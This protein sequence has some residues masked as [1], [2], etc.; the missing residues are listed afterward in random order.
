M[1][2]IYEL[3]CHTKEVS[4]CSKVGVEQLVKAHK[5]AGFS[6]L[7]IT[8]HY[9][10]GYFDRFS[11]KSDKEIVTE[12]L[13][14]FHKALA[15]GKQIGLTVLQGMEIRFSNNTNDY[16]LFGITEQFIYDNPRFFELTLEEFVSTLKTNEMVLIWA[17]PFRDGITMTN[18]RYLDGVEIVNGNFRHNPRNYLAKEYAKRANLFGTCGSDYHQLDDLNLASMKFF[19]KINDEK[20]LVSALRNSQ[21]TITDSKG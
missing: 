6:G 8:D 19:K 12:Y 16:L 5:E 20:E 11:N 10:D 15:I 4:S 18:E 17:H 1:E 7:C 13:S 3:H 9:F 21:Y 2:Y 14:G